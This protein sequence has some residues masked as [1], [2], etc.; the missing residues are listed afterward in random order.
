MCYLKSCFLQ[1]INSKLE[2]VHAGQDP[3]TGS[4]KAEPQ[5]T[6]L[7]M[8]LGEKDALTFRQE[9]YTRS[10]IPTEAHWASVWL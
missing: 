4:P 6:H 8:K 1:L 10:F 7:F 3:E 5:R 9:M 2:V